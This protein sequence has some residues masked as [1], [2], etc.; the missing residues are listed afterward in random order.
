MGVNT[1][2]LVSPEKATTVSRTPS[3]WHRL[4]PGT[5]TLLPRTLDRKT[6][7][8]SSP[9]IFITRLLSRSTKPDV[10]GRCRRMLTSSP[11]SSQPASLATVEAAKGRP[12][13]KPAKATGIST[14]LT[15]PC[16]TLL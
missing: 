11:A 1:M 7:G 4:P 9:D 2:E 3:T 5:R 16:L 12:Q 15:F 14:P 10:Q 8:G 13:G 6:D